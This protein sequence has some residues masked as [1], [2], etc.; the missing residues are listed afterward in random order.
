M[1]EKYLWRQIY[2][3]LFLGANC[4]AVKNDSALEHERSEHSWPFC[5]WIY[6]CFPFRAWNSWRRVLK[7]VTQIYSQSFLR[8]SAGQK[9][10]SEH[11]DE[12][13]FNDFSKSTWNLDLEWVMCYFLCQIFLFTL[14][15]FLLL[16]MLFFFPFTGQRITGISSYTLT[17]ALSP[18]AVEYRLIDSYSHSS[19]SGTL[20][21]YWYLRG[22]QSAVVWTWLRLALPSWYEIV[23]RIFLLQL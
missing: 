14:S 5:V 16:F 8:R 12:L 15:Y 23:T 7:S 22:W 18:S 1:I 19:F 10:S 2:W 20:T 6:E 17:F 21:L 3:G 11:I 9:M 13:F 4:L